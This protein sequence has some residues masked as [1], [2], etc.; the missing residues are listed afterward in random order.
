MPAR[1]ADTSSARAPALIIM[2][3]TTMSCSME[4]LHLL[5]DIAGENHVYAGESIGQDYTHDECASVSGTPD[6]RQA[7]RSSRT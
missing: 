7:I 1:S 4:I 3:E 5:K 2:E 6:R